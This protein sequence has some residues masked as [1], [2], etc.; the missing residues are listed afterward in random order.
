MAQNKRQQGG[1]PPKNREYPLRGKVFCSECKSAMTITT[2][3]GN[4]YYYRCTAKKR[5]H[6]CEGTSIRA[7]ILEDHVAEALKIALGT[8]ENV[9][10]LIR[11]LRDQAKSVQSGAVDKLQLLIQRSQEVSRKLDNAVDAV[12]NGLSSQTIKNRIAE[13]EQEKAVIEHD[14]AALKA[15]VDAS[16]VPETKLR[17]LIKTAAEAKDVPVL[18]S[19]V[20]RV[21]VSRDS[22]TIWTLLDADPSGNINLDNEGVIITPGIPFGVPLTRISQPGYPG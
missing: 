15:S 16:A 21:E 11:I 13:L 19:I 12:L 17:E 6:N 20:Y 7:D 8:P 2:S 10:G 22:I 3:R 4:Y 9:N 14:I 1:R 5:L 18:F